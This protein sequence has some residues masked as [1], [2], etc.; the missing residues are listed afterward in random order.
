[1]G[2]REQQASYCV[3]TVLT[4]TYYLHLQQSRQ[5]H[6]REQAADAFGAV[7]CKHDGCAAAV[8][9]TELEA[10]MGECGWLLVLCPQGCGA[11][12]TRDS[13]L[14]GH[15]CSVP[16]L[17]C[18]VSVSRREHAAHLEANHTWAEVA[19]KQ[20]AMQERQEKMMERQ[21]EAMEKQELRK[22]W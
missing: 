17:C 21:N 5:Q 3:V 8:K 11:M 10:H 18:G 1:M 19:L 16:C 14:D 2:T 7:V 13:K 20:V 6:A 9:Y 12:V 15:D 4:T 22:W